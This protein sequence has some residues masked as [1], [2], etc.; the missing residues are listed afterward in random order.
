MPPTPLSLPTDADLLSLP[1]PAF[2]A[3]PPAIRHP[4]LIPEPILQA[5]RGTWAMGRFA[6]RRVRV[7]RLRN[8]WVAKEGLVFDRDGALYR[9]TVTQHSP[10]EVAAAQDAVLAAIAS[11]AGAS[12]MGAP[13][14]DGPVVLC[15]KRGVGNY[16][17]WM[18]EM[19]PKAHLVH[20]HLPELGARFLVADVP[21][22]LRASMGASLALLGIDPARAVVVGDA[23]RRFAEL[24]LVEGLTEH[25]A[26]MSPLVM[27]CVEALA[28]AVGERPARPLFVT[29]QAM[30]FRRLVGEDALLLRAQE[31]GCVPVEPA[32][33]PLPDQI[34]LFKGAARVTGVMG[35]AM[36]NIAFAAPGT[37]VALLTPA[38]MPDTF[39]WF[40]ATLRGLDYTEI[41]CAQAGPVR[42]NM[43]WDTDL[44]LDPADAAE[45]LGPTGHAS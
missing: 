41:R 32:L 22:A 30:G 33:L 2:D 18:M 27:D 31:A 43:P 6:E 28:R 45:L 5:M 36:T 39:F 19:L 9:E 8:V 3:R 16:G 23:P 1:S 34:A 15:K 24:L 10:A 17:H 12:G 14:R 21:G 29:R 38:G 13:D 44:I 40:I 11:G 20:T 35:A 25:G 37:P 7:L 26:Y 4:D 42:G